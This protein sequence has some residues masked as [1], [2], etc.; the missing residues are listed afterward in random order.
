MT[1]VLGDKLARAF[2]LALGLGLVVATIVVAAPA[3]GHGGVLPASLRVEAGQ[4]GAIAVSPAAPEPVLRAP[5]MR[6]GSHASGTL[7]LTNQTG[8]VLAVGL[9]AEPSSTAL[10]GLAHVRIEG[11]GEL[12]ADTTLQALRRRSEGSVRLA[13]GEAAKLR[14]RVSI[15]A[16]AETGYEG[17]SVGVTLVPVYGV[18]P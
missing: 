9:R 13:P 2:G 11:G 4:D 12:L 5:S 7:S 17:A 18:A 8:E 3:G 15:P 16:D 10:D 14:V 1:V 6:P